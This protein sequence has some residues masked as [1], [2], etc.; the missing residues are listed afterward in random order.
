MFGVP[1]GLLSLSF[2][3]WWKGEL[4]F[5]GSVGYYSCVLFLFL[6]SLGCF[7]LSLAR[8]RKKLGLGR[9]LV[10]RSVARF[11]DC[12]FWFDLDD[13]SF[14]YGHSDTRKANDMSSSLSSIE[15]EKR[16]K[17]KSRLGKFRE[18]RLSYM[19]QSKKRESTYFS[20]TC[21]VSPNGTTLNSTPQQQRLF[22]FSFFVPIYCFPNPSFLAAVSFAQGGT[23][24]RTALSLKPKQR[25]GEGLKPSRKR[26][27]GR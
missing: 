26:Q 15:R 5:L 7:F 14:F 4:L 18:K 2:G 1:I 19:P 16:E 21:T 11:S 23:R 24:S 17:R 3:G 20:A 27:G 22:S 10:F 9:I 6:K 25:M 8:I 12:P 13:C